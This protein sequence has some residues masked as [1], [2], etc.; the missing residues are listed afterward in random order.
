[1]KQCPACKREFNEQAAFC[2]FD[3]TSLDICNLL[4]DDKYLL[5]EKIGEGGMGQVY[6]AT[7]VHIDTKFAVKIL[8]PRLVSDQVAMERFRREARAAAQIHHPNAVAVTDFGV[9]KENNIV[10]LVMEFLRGFSL[11]ERINEKKQFEYKETFLILR[12][13]CAAI[14]MAHSKGI[15]HRD[16]KPDNIFIIITED[17]NEHVKVLDFGIA[18][19]KNYT[20]DAGRSLTQEGMIIGTPFYMSPEQWRSEELDARSDIY[21]LGIILYEMLTGRVPFFASTPMAVGII[22]STES[23]KPLRALRPDI[24]RRVEEVVLR[25]LA[26]KREDR[27]ESAIKLVQEF[28]AALSPIDKAAIKVTPSHSSTSPSRREGRISGSVELAE[29]LEPVQVDEENF[30]PVAQ[31]DIKT[32]ITPIKSEGQIDDSLP[33]LIEPRAEQELAIYGD[34]VEAERVDEKGSIKAIG[35]VPTESRNF[36]RKY[37]LLAG[38]AILSLVFLITFSVLLRPN[39]AEVQKKKPEIAPPPTPPGMILI[40]GGRFIMGNDT[41]EYEAEKPEYETRVDPFFIDQN[42]VTNEEYDKFIKE[43]R[44]PP[45]PHWKN[46]SFLSGEDRYPVVNISWADAK[47]FAEWAGK[48]LPTEKEWEFAARGADKRLYPWG[49]DFNPRNTNSKETDKKN[50]MPV[51]SYP[52]GA[53]PFQLMDIAGNVAEWT[54][55]DYVPY[56]NSQAKPEP[57]KK[58]VRGCSYLC[59]KAM[60]ILTHR[61]RYTPDT[62]RTDLGF[63][64]AKDA[65]LP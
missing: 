60:L 3:G 26:K 40:S 45:P 31:E 43:K 50:P 6:R 20:S 55:S 65:N 2:P 63:R 37:R 56:H 16:L 57:G 42:E 21:S 62:R 15:I 22:Q 32:V 64:C 47:A 9:T 28:E 51:G 33:T 19:L 44:Y 14:Q 11:R 38:L 18:K 61:Y 23:P 52:R 24:P 36:A 17:N 12:Q 35:S 34:T 10:Y 49:N 13:I 27:Q 29:G 4:L 8:H 41:S 46:G 48:R 1:M 53:S 54:A 58:V 7:H 39:P 25:A 59:D 30:L 5:E